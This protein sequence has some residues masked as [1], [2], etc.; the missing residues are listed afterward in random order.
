M[1]TKPTPFTG[2]AA[3]EDVAVPWSSASLDEKFCAFSDVVFG[4]PANSSWERSTPESIIVSGRPGP[5]AVQS[6]APTWG[7]HHCVAA[8]GSVNWLR[9]LRAPRGLVV[10]GTSGVTERT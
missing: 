8:S 6:S 1:P 4:R 10:T 7:T 9:K 5:G 2:A 3:T